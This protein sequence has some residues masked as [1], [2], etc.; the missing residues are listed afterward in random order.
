MAF[1]I[2]FIPYIAA[3]AVAVVGSQQKAGAEKYR[4]QVDEQNAQLTRQQTSAAEDAQRRQAAMQLGT[5]RAAASESGFD[6]N[7]GSL[8]AIQI[9]SAGEMELDILTNR[10][11]GELEALGLQN[12]AA[13]GRQN[14]RNTKTSGYLSAAGTLFGGQTNYLSQSMIKGPT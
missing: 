5:M 7:S 6:P 13:V 8:A 4:A 1:V 3:A 9:K 14:A 12:D 2:P 10:Y 11:R